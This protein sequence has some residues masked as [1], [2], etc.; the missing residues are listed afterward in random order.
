MLTASTH[1][2]NNM[3]PPLL[4]IIMLTTSISAPAQIADPTEFFKSHLKGEPFMK[5][6]ADLNGDGKAEVMLSRKNEFIKD[7]EENEPTGWYVYISGATGYTE[8]K[9]LKNQ[10]EESVSPAALPIDLK[11]CYT[12]PIEELGNNT[13]VVTEEIETPAVGDPIVRIYA[14]TVEGDHLLRTKLAEYN[15]LQPNPLF[16]KYLKEGKRTVIT[17]VEM[18]K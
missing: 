2:S 17:P 9:G 11:A 4:S 18:S 5:W 7:N 13:G 10:G 12:G 8:F 6:E 1:T 15:A 14:Y 16:D 3:K